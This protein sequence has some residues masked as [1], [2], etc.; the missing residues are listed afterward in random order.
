LKASASDAAYSAFS[1]WD[2]RH[3][4]RC[5]AEQEHECDQAEHGRTVAVYGWPE[6]G[7]STTDIGYLM[8]DRTL[9]REYSACAA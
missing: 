6:F 4:H 7:L 3:R 8:P 1:A 2:G 9:A 5:I